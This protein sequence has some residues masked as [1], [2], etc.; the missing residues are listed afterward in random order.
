MEALNSGL[1]SS[2]SFTFSLMKK[3]PM[4]MAD[5]L[6]RAEKYV[7]AKEGMA[8][9]KQKISWS[10]HQEEKGEHSRNASEKREKRKERFELPR[11][12][13][14]HKLSRRESLSRGGAPISSYNNV[15]PLLDTC[16]RILTAEQDNVPI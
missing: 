7:N 9:W 3:P 14:R 16:T 1:R 4:D 15:A 12:D 13:L 6:R 11:D 2:S 10:G 5:L 8:A